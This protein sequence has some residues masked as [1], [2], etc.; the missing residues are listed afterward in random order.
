MITIP[1]NVLTNL[2][3]KLSVP[4]KSLKF[5]GG[6]REDS[7]GTVFTFGSNPLK[8]LKVLALPLSDTLSLAKLDDRLNFAHFVGESGIQVACPIKNKNGTLYE[9]VPF[10]GH[11]FTAYLMDYCSG[12]TPMKDECTPAFYKEWGRVT[13]RMHRAAKSYPYWLTLPSCASSGLNGW[14]QETE[15][16]YNWCKDE[17]VKQKWLQ[18]QERL[19][20]LPINR[21]GFGF[22]H[23]DNHIH[24]ITWNGRGITLLDFDVANCQF[25]IS[26]LTTAMQMLLFDKSGG[27]IGEVTDYGVI[28][29]FLESFLCGYE[30][31]SHLDDF[32]LSQIDTFISYR[33][34]LLFT[35]MQDYLHRNQQLKEQ[36]L[37]CI[38]N[39][40][41]IFSVYA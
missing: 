10:G 28:R 31:E 40:P 35:V 2:C 24:N 14:Q 4:A 23:N 34:L 13:G 41:A 27:M 7:D 11:L 38:Y 33:R 16:F 39:E 3:D 15:M 25:F 18:M 6:G 8:V 12:G 20:Q 22:I 17:A 32:W 1:N 29:D 19:E 9:S 37:D 30:Q 36:F 21:E 5:L 26:D